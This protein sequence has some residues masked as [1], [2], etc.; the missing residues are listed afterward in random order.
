MEQAEDYGYEGDEDDW[1]AAVKEI[2]D[3]RYAGHIPPTWLR[4]MPLQRAL[5]VAAAR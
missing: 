2:G 4:E 5:H 1:Q 3:V